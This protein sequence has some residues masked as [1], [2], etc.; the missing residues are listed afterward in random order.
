M[1]LYIPGEILLSSYLKNNEATG[2]LSSAN[3]KRCNLYGSPLSLL[4]WRVF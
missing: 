4:P 1:L 3:A 2:P